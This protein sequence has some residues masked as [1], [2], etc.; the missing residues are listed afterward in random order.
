MRT[1]SEV[2]GEKPGRGMSPLR[3]KDT[4]SGLDKEATP[5]INPGELVAEIRREFEKAVDPKYRE[6]VQRFF[7]E[8][9]DVY[10]VRTADARRISNEYFNKVRHL[11]KREILKMCEMLHSGLGHDPKRRTFRSCPA[12]KY[13]EHGIA[14][15]WAGKLSAKLEPADFSILEGWLKKHVS[16]WAA[17]DTLCGGPL[18]EFLLRFP[19]FLPRVQKW[20]RSENR[21]LRRASAV[22]LILAAKREKYLSE[23]YK[24]ADIL[25]EDED[26]MVQK[27]YGWL[28][29][30]IA[31]KRPQEVLDFV[32]K[33]KAT[34]PRT[35]LR[36]AIEKMPPAWKK[37]AMA[38]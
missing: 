20:A 37:R 5:E 29:K 30:E 7:K 22:A 19:Q 26:D 15:I 3:Y 6:S 23:A 17:C 1:K 2:R 10:G 34:M 18:G 4:K 25:L 36:Y 24:T 28:L 9:I 35:A 16:N 11:P 38:T 33:R 8:P 12:P 14:F 13:E 31:N 21:W 27:G 32:M